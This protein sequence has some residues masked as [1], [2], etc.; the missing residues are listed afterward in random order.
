MICDYVENAAVCT[1]LQEDIYCARMKTWECWWKSA[2]HLSNTDLKWILRKTSFICKRLI[3]SRLIITFLPED[4]QTVYVLCTI[5]YNLPSPIL[6]K[7]LFCQW[8]LWE[9]EEWK[10]NLFLLFYSPV[11]LSI[12]PILS[13]HLLITRVISALHGPSTSI[14]STRQT[15]SIID[16]SIGFFNEYLLQL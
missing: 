6:K 1:Q 9:H 3:W 16:F 7:C 2:I 4:W 8:L 13:A 5:R 15:R 11:R 12:K 14:L 10:I